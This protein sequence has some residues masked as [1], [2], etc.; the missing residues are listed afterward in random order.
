MGSTPAPSDIVREAAEEDSK[1]ALEVS[2]SAVALLHSTG[3]LLSDCSRLSYLRKFPTLAVQ[4]CA[5]ALFHRTT[6]S[7][8]SDLSGN[9]GSAPHS[10]AYAVDEI[11]FLPRPCSVAASTHLA[12]EP[13]HKLAWRYEVTR[14]NSIVQFEIFNPG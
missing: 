2:C 9:E 5:A 11:S 10:R 1:A 8:G 12:T 6:S 13:E 7:T 4:P 3:C 14:A